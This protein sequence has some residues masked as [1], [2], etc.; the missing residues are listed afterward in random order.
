VARAVLDTEHMRNLLAALLFST[1]VLACS[2]TPDAGTVAP[3]AADPAPTSAPAA[4]APAPTAAADPTPAPSAGAVAAPTP[5]PVAVAADAAPDLVEAAPGVQVVADYD[6]PV[7]FNSG[8]YWR[9]NDGGWYSSSVYTGGWEYKASPPSVIVSIDRP[10]RFVHYRPS[11]YVARRQPAP[12]REW[13]PAPVHA[14]VRAEPH[15]E[16]R[17]APH[18]EVRVDPHAEIRV[19]PHAEVHVAPHAEV[20]VDSHAEVHTAPVVVKAVPKPVARDHRD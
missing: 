18:A 10:E 5:A 1:A 9:Y 20:R 6:T 7:F 13:H 11:G 4:T 3:V 2:K 12:Q 17:V 19:A 14:E 16:V 15:A 8:L